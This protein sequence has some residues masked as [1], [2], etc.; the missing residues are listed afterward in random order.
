RK[1]EEGP[2]PVLQF[3]LHQ[4]RPNKMRFEIN[5]AGQRTV[6]IFDGAHGWNVRPGGP[7]GTNGKPYTQ[8]EVTFAFRAQGIDGPLIDYKAKGSQVE[9]EG[10][11]LI[12]GHKA[13]RLKVQLASGEMDHVW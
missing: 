3:A 1:P 6:R 11:E 2:A 9:L 4:Q 13:Y 5:A 10:M 12:Q 7:T 8:Q